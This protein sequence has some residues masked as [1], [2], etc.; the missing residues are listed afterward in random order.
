M[1]RAIKDLGR[2]AGL[3]QVGGSRSVPVLNDTR[4]LPWLAVLA[5][6]WESTKELFRT[7]VNSHVGQ[8]G[9]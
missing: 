9:K 8:S 7:N 3:K 5:A 6:L 1:Q 2:V 4:N